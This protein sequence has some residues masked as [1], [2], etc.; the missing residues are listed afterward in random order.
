MATDFPTSA[1]IRHQTPY[2]HGRGAGSSRKLHSDSQVQ[3]PD[4]DPSRAGG[5]RKWTKLP[6]MQLATEAEVEL[7]R[8]LAYLARE[9]AKTDPDRHEAIL[10]DELG[11]LKGTQAKIHVNPK[12]PYFHK[13]RPVPFALKPKLEQELERL[14]RE[15]II[16]PVQ[17]SDWAALI[18]PV[19]KSNCSIRICGD[20]RLTVNQ[21]SRFDAYPLPKVGKL[22]ASYIRP[23]PEACQSPSSI[24]SMPTSNSHWKRVRNLSPRSTPIEGYST[25]IDYHLE[26]HLLLGF[27]NARW[28]IYSKACLLMSLCIWT[29]FSSQEK[30]NSSI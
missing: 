25:T 2:L 13:A 7:A 3:G 26:S 10:K 18:M 1:T 14:D 21:A 8:Y 15:R 6:G 5:G 24:F 4:R 28:T 12:A 9:D 30:Q 17:F 29:I 22:F 19:V 20:Y 27:S 11:E 23:W 16:T